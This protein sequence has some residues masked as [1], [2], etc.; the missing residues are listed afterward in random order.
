MAELVVTLLINLVVGAAVSLAVK[1]LSPSTGTD[2]AER[3][4][5]PPSDPLG[6]APDPGGA[7]IGVAG[8]R[9]VGGV[10]VWEGKSTVDS[11]TYKLVVLASDVLNAMSTVFINDTPV[12]INGSGYVT[13]APWTSNSV[14]IKLYDGTQVAADP[15]MRAAFT[16]WSA[17][18]IGK[19]HAYARI[20]LDPSVGGNPF[21]QGTPD[22][23]FNVQGFK[24]YDPRDDAQSATDK[25]TWAYTD[26]SALVCAG[27]LMHDLGMKVPASEVD[28]ASVIAAANICDEQV[29]LLAGGSENR[30]ACALTW[31]TN[32]R[33][34]DVLARIGATMAGG[35]YFVGDK[36]R[37]FAGHFSAA[38]AETITPA[39]YEGNGLQWSEYRPISEIVNGV[40][41][42]FS[43]PGNA[44]EKR[45]FPAY[46]DAGA[47]AA[48][49]SEFWL[50]L[51][52][53]AVTS[54]SQAQRLARIAYKKR[55][56]GYPARLETMF[57]H[58]DVVANDIVLV[59]DELAGFG[60]NPFRVIKERFN[61]EK[62]VCEFEMEHE[63]ADFYDWVAANDEKAFVTEPPL[64]IGSG[65][66]SGSG[67][68]A[69]RDLVTVPAQ[70]GVLYDAAG[71]AGT[72]TPQMEVWCETGLQTK[73]KLYVVERTVGDTIRYN[74]EETTLRTSGN[75]AFAYNMPAGT[76]PVSLMLSTKATRIADGAATSPASRTIASISPS[77]TLT[78]N[79]VRA[80]LDGL[81][82]AT[83]SYFALPAPVCPSVTAAAPTTVTI[84]A[85]QM[86]STT[87]ITQ[88]E[89][90]VNTTNDPN[91][92]TVHS[93]GANGV[94]GYDATVTK[95]SGQSRYYWT[96]ARM[97]SGVVGP[98]SP[99][100]LVD[101]A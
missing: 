27:Y 89:L 86:I 42:T 17:D 62:Y 29:A 3:K 84:N 25:T 22:F 99:V 76:A 28:W 43:S 32:E 40:R 11:K 49:G 69:T 5:E 1:A 90:L 68:V 59:T 81:T 47:L 10:V 70:G 30:Y 98:V 4:G 77:F 66:S 14:R 82:A 73:T 55:R 33:H 101:Y 44:Y 94:G 7:C 56:F 83:S 52:L 18:Y 13:T 95:I 26:N 9:R 92:A 87:R 20:I 97:A 15:E 6:V 78:Y 85:P 48:D 12:S 64:L 39:T 58:F 21:S 93:T 91:T 51:D 80:L 50:D 41:G 60:S 2:F 36:W 74:V 67:Y 16:G 71:A 65:G 45:D 61:A 54:P 8:S 37:V 79:A 31:R 75:T 96:R 19:K 72:V 23:T 53:S 24:F 46:Q 63:R 35:G 100:M 38:G 34:E 57:N 88:I